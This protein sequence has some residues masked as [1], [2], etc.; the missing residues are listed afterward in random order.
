MMGFSDISSTNDGLGPRTGWDDDV[1]QVESPL[2]YRIAREVTLRGGWQ[3]TAF[4]TGPEDPIDLLAVQ[5]R[6]VF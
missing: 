6:V 4:M 5:L 2:S 3:H 1:F